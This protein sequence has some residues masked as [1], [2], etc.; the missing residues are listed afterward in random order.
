MRKAY[1]YTSVEKYE[2]ILR[3]GILRVNSPFT[4]PY[5]QKKCPEIEFPETKFTFAFLDT[6]EPEGWKNSGFLS[7]LLDTFFKDKYLVLLSFPI[8]EYKTFVLEARP[9]YDMKYNG[10]E[11]EES[12]REYVDSMV[13]LDLYTDNFEMPELII[14]DDISIEDI[15]AEK[16]LPAKPKRVC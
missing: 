7:L 14:A 5:Y 16:Y 15:T 10:K 12:F 8:E 3:G 6:P 1:H 4:P 13:E 2:R 9:I 11:V